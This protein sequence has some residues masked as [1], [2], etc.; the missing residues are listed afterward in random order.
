MARWGVNL[1][2][3][4]LSRGGRSFILFWDPGGHLP[5]AQGHYLAMQR[6]VTAPLALKLPSWTFR[7]CPPWPLKLLFSKKIIR[8]FEKK[9]PKNIKIYFK[10]TEIRREMKGGGRIFG[11]PMGKCPPWLKYEMTPLRSP[12]MYKYIFIFNF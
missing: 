7:I 1:T 4:W 12:E 3:S 6:G 2:P 9:L 8:I 10:V 11:E 5:T